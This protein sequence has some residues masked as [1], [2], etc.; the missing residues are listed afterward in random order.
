[1]S[2]ATP[3]HSPP[4]TPPTTSPTKVAAASFVGTTVEWYDYFLF[5]TAAVLVFDTQFFPT[6][7]PA[8]ATLAALATFAVA[9]VARPLGG[10]VFGHFGDRLSRKSML[11][12]SLLAMGAATFAIGLLPN[13]ATI[14]I[15]APV[16]LVTLRLIQGLAVGGEWGGAIVMALE[17]APPS[18]KSFYASWPQAGVPAGIVLSSGIFYLVQLMPEAQ[19]QSWG[20]RIPFLLSAV[21]IMVGLMIRLRIEE[22]P[23][24]ASMQEEKKDRGIPLVELLR[25]S[26]RAIVVSV[27]S[28]AGSN[29]LFYVATVYLLS[30]GTDVAQFERGHILL[31][32]TLGAFLDIFAIPLVAVLADRH[33]RQRMMLVGTAVTAASAFPIFWLVN[34]GTTWGLVAA[35]VLAL[36]VAHSFVYAT[37]SGFIAT[38]FRPEVRF[39]GSSVSYQ[40]GGI[41]TSAPAP[42]LASL[43]YLEFNTYAAVAGYLVAANVVAFIAVLCAPAE[44]RAA[45]PRPTA[46]QTREAVEALVR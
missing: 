9:F 46:D 1:M 25:T 22:S 20:W 24:F 40:V 13:Y 15:A 26:K 8:A 19:L 6:L 18:R 27:L 39:T 44:H 43:L 33:G 11:V 7:D 38:L 10:V 45:D 2:T 17:H 29:T 41:V 37:V 30:Y 14:G 36:P 35:L 16:L 32:I 21:L 34:L 5:G 31:A 28:L 42:I 4:S 12:W 3:L 23:E